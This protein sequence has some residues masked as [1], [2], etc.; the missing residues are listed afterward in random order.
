M[1]LKASDTRL[2]AARL[3]RIFIRLYWQFFY[4]LTFQ[5]RIYVTTAHN[6][7]NSRIIMSELTQ[8]KKDKE[9]VAMLKLKTLI[10]LMGLL[11]SVYQP[12][13]A[14]E[15]AIKDNTSIVGTWKM[16]SYEIEIQASGQKEA[17]FG[18]HPTGYVIFTPEGRAIYLATG[19]GRQVPN[20]VQDRADLWGS[21]FAW[22]GRYRVEGNKWIVKIDASWS[23][24]LIGT[25]LMRYFKI[26]G[27]RMYFTSDYYVSQSRIEKG[28]IR[29]SAVWERE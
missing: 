29:Q 23:P 17:Y 13:F 24:A 9:V 27:N 4:V 3:H 10:V 21:M 25:D 11:I 28:P 12:C 18:Q 16:V 19:E 5:M 22:S 26:E 8:N 14:A 1:G 7:K 15:N 2:K 6:R 20:S